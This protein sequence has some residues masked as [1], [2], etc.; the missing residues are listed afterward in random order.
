MLVA[1][2]FGLL[3]VVALVGAYL[4]SKHWHW[5]HV[6]IAV[7]LFFASVGFTILAADALRVRTKWQ[8]QLATDEPKLEEVDRRNATLRRGT[9]KAELINELS[10]L[11]VQ[12][13]PQAAAEDDY[14]MPGLVDLAHRLRLANRTLGRVWRDGRPLGGVNP[15]TRQVDVGIG[16][17]QPA[18]IGQGAILFVFEQGDPNPASPQ[19]GKQY[20]GEFRVVAAAEQQV[21]LEP[22]LS[23][24]PYEAQRLANSRGPWTLYETMP[25]DRRDAFEGFTEAELRRVLPPASVEEYLREGTDWTVDDGEWTKAG[26]DR[27]GQPLGPDEWDDQTKYVY[28]RRLRDYAFLFNDLAKRRIEM[29]ARKLALAED[30]AK[31]KATLARAQKITADKQAEQGMLQSDLEGVKRDRMAIEA[32]AAAVEQ[33]VAAAERLLQRTLAANTRL[34]RSLKAR[35]AELAGGRDLDR[36]P[37]PSRGALDIDAL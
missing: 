31:L 6:L 11:G 30:I 14:Q 1:A 5:A 8:K 4:A 22:V 26:L 34:A 17:P 27:A 32:H 16:A 18:G 10:A 3:F 33:Q 9:D 13:D 28:Q 24:D 19:Q 36:M 35:Q 25:V 2:S 20:L 21:R 12:I 23:L 7:A 15:Q 37:L 29:E